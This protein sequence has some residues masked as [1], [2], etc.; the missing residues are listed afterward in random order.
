MILSKLA[1]MVETFRLDRLNETFD[2]RVQI[3]RANE[4]LFVLDLCVFQGRLEVIGELRVTDVNRVSRAV[5]ADSF[6]LDEGSNPARRTRL[7]TNVCPGS[8]HTWGR[9]P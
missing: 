9:T 6:L 2:S 3:G 1:E 5:F 4:E 8:R 7:T